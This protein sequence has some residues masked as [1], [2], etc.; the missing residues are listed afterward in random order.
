MKLLGCFGLRFAILFGLLVWPWSGLRTTIGAVFRAQTRLLA[1]TMPSQPAISVE[2]FSDPH[3]PGVDTLVVLAD[4]KTTSPS[5][6]QSVVEIPFDSASQGWIPFAM[7]IALTVATPLPWPK[8]WQAL[9]VGAL[10]IQLLIAVSIWVS[11]SFGLT[12]ENSPAWPRLPLLFAHRLLVENL[13]FSFVP[14]FLLWAGWLAWSGH[15]KL[16]AEQLAIHQEPC[17][18]IQN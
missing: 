9:L 12:N 8:R 17:P 5:G 11:L 3:H 10:V 7:L 2:K 6:G 14:S 18:A 4:P 16:L 15:W 1:R 13:W